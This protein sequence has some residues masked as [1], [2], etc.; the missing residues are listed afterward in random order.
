MKKKHIVTAVL[1]AYVLYSACTPSGAMKLQA[2]IISR[3]PAV[4]F[5]SI[6]L[7]VFGEPYYTFQND[8]RDYDTGNTLGVFTYRRTFLLV[9]AEYV[10][11][12]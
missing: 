10:G 1:G 6:E 7:S 3:N 12:P 11:F 9:T 5:N 8:V 4:Y 2:L